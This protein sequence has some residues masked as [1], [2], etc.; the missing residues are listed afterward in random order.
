MHPKRVVKTEKVSQVARDYWTGLDADWDRRCHANKVPDV[1]SRNISTSGRRERREHATCWS[2]VSRI[3]HSPPN[4]LGRMFRLPRFF[5][6]LSLSF[7]FFGSCFCW[8]RT[9]PDCS[10]GVGVLRST[11]APCVCRSGVCTAHVLRSTGDLWTCCL[12]FVWSIA[13]LKRWIWLLRP[14]Y[15]GARARDPTVW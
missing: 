5:F 15:P 7:S 12:G 8:R 10:R 6:S 1:M 11:L 4:F 13:F 3:G 14:V 2:L 9:Q